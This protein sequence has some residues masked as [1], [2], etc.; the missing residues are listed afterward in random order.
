[1]ASHKSKYPLPSWY[2]SFN[3]LYAIKHGKAALEEL[4]SRPE[5]LAQL[6]Q[7]LN[8]FVSWVGHE[9]LCYQANIIEE[10][11]DFCS[12]RF[13][14]RKRMFQTNVKK[15]KQITSAVFKRDNYTCQYCGQVGGVLECDHKIPFSKGGSDELEN[16]TT[17][18]RKCN[19]SKRDK[20][21][22]EFK[23]IRSI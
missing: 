16:L 3:D 2:K 5:L 11:A 21:D 10:V 22:S 6:G 23:A 9:R 15:W 8:S 12:G 14:G 17:A 13:D 7:S 20:T 18:C 1:M 19:R 4:K